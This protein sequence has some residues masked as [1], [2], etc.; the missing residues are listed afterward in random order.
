MP[1]RLA[2][3]GH[4][5]SSVHGHRTLEH[6]PKLHART[7]IPASHVHATE[8]PLLESVELRLDDVGRGVWNVEF[9]GS[10]RTGRLPP[11]FARTVL[12]VTTTSA[13][14]RGIHCSSTTSTVDG[15]VAVDWTAGSHGGESSI[16]AKTIDGSM[17]LTI[18]GQASTS[19]YSP[20][21]QSRL[22]TYLADQR[23]ARALTPQQLAAAIGYRN[24]SKGGNRIV[25]LE[26]AG[27]SDDTEVT[28]PYDASPLHRATQPDTRSPDAQPM[29]NALSIAGR[30][31]IR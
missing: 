26:A 13:P 1:Q 21:M 19:V 29:T 2:S 25:A 12:D 14:G 15:C 30:S 23:R 9:S 22:G 20:S 27:I 8:T 6:Q 5:R 3:F 4:F 17:V 24:V 7:G 16:T 11:R 18:L 28:F 10:V 31:T